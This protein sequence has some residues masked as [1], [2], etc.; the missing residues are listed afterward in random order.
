[1]KRKFLQNQELDR[2]GF[3]LAV[4]QS[5]RWASSPSFQLAHLRFVERSRTEYFGSNR[6]K[7][8]QSPR[9]R[10]VGD[11]HEAVKW[12]RIQINTLWRGK[13]ALNAPTIGQI[14]Y[15]GFQL[16]NLNSKRTQ[17]AGDKWNWKRCI[18]ELAFSE[19]CSFFQEAYSH[20]KEQVRLVDL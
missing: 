14:L 16:N 20:F 15:H 7:S 6:R 10:T 4:L 9:I 3:P 5:D 8:E 17:E 19:Y 1:M 18:S 11:L 2:M 12:P 13:V